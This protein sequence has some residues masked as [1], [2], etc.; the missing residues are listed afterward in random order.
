MPGRSKSHK[1]R[2]SWT[3]RRSSSHSSGGGIGSSGNGGYEPKIQKQGWTGSAKT[4]S[5]CLPKLF[6]LTLPFITLGSFL[7]LRSWK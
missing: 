5:S 2:K 7:L 1:A 4:K 6:M 3:S